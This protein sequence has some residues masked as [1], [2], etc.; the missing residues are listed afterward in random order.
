MHQILSFE[1]YLLLGE[2]KYKFYAIKLNKQK[3]VYIHCKIH[4]C[5][6]Q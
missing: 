2:Q 4:K 3:E 1:Y 5:C 6:K